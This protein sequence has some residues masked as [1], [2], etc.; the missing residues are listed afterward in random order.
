MSTTVR[1]QLTTGIAAL[2]VGAIMAAAITATP[3]HPT[4][5]T[6]PHRLGVA[7]SAELAALVNPLSAVDQTL[8]TTV[9]DVQQF[10]TGLS[11]NP[12]I[13]SLIGARNISALKQL[14][15]IGQSA[16]TDFGTSLTEDLSSQAQTVL[17]LVQTGNW[18]SA[19]DIVESTATTIQSV[20]PIVLQALLIG[21]AGQLLQSI[22]PGVTALQTALKTGNL[23][24]A[25]NAVATITKTVVSSV[26][27]QNGLI[28]QLLAIAQAL[29]RT[30]SSPAAATTAAA[31]LPATAAKSLTLST[32][33]TAAAVATAAAAAAKPTATSTSKTKKD[34]SK[35]HAGTADNTEA[36]DK[37]TSTADS[38][39]PTASSSAADSSAE[40]ADMPSTNTKGGK[41]KHSKTDHQKGRHGNAS[42]QGG[43]RSHHAAG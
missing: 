12:L 21:S 31:N 39:S 18:Q 30:D 4:A 38:S 42:H 2:S 22:T 9:T 11:S 34:H 43:G 41:A 13:T 26:L 23:G 20:P 29:G 1:P 6:F 19:L 40:S 28:S 35:K 7:T 10:V 17:Q 37:T 25:L 15:T 36:A 27:G 24:K 33:A 14:V 8:Q 32:T 5:A 3:Q 16:L